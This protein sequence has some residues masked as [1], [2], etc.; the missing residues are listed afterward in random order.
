[1]LSSCACI[2]KSKDSNTAEEVV[3]L[4][5]TSTKCFTDDVMAEDK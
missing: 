3:Y 4:K 2:N 1:M 5:Y